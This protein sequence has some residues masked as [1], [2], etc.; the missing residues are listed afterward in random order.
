MMISGQVSGSCGEPIAWD[1]HCPSGSEAAPLVI[2]LHGKQYQRCRQQEKE[3]KGD[4][5]GDRTGH[6][7]GDA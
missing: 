1:L 3:E 5:H 2:I 6:A 7:R 4:S